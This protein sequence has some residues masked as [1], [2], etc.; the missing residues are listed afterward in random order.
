[1]L[2]THEREYILAKGKRRRTIEV[3]GNWIVH[4][5]PSRNAVGIENKDLPKYNSRRIVQPDALHDVTS[6]G[7]TGQWIY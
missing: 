3:F 4:T 6:E 5:K 2:K 1:M 7:V